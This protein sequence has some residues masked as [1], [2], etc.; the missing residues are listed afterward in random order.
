MRE[1][2]RE[3]AAVKDRGN[4]RPPGGIALPAHVERALGII[5]AG[6][7]HELDE[8]R[9]LR[10]LLQVVHL[11][12]RDSTANLDFVATLEPIAAELK[13]VAD[14]VSKLQEAMRS[15]SLAG[16]RAYVASNPL[17]AEAV[18]L[19]LVE[20]NRTLMAAARVSASAKGRAAADALHNSAGGTRD[21]KAAM[22]SA[23][24]TGKYSSRDRCAEEECAALE[25]S[26]SS[27]RKA[28]RNTP[29]PPI[30]PAAAG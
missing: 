15:E 21:K 24:A 5:T 8:A 20:R 17:S 14:E 11:N 19:L 25:M 13:R 6:I 12:T 18:A 9:V 23:W 22:Q 29:K 26:L 10:E 27:A 28:L 1:K 7:D 16:W 30:S 3:G 2:L 4:T